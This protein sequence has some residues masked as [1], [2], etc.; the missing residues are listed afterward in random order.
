MR[1][2]EIV[3]LQWG[4]L[5][6]RGKFFLLWRQFTRG[7]I[8]P[9]KTGKPRRVDMS[10]ALAAELQGLKKRRQA[11]YLAKGSNEI[12]QWVFCNQGGESARLLQ[13]EASAF[14]KVPRARRTSQNSFSRSE[15]YLRHPALDARRKPRVCERATR[16]FQHQS[17]GRYLRPLDSRRKSSSGES[18]SDSGEFGN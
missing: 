10:D 15:A 2:S 5:D 3:G 7:R 17:L 6:F 8:E 11:E 14:R 12:P 13:P 18:A 4:D 1:A 9:T 16:A